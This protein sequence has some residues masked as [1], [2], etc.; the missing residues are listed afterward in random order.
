M[1][2]AFAVLLAPA[3]PGV[4]SA[5]RGLASQTWAELLAPPWIRPDPDHEREGALEGERAED[6]R[7]ARAAVLAM[8]AYIRAA[9][10]TRSADEGTDSATGE[11]DEY[12]GGRDVDMGLIRSLF[13]AGS[14]LSCYTGPR[15]VPWSGSEQGEL[16]DFLSYLLRVLGLHP[17]VTVREDELLASALTSAGARALDCVSH[18][19]LGPAL[20]GDAAHEARTGLPRPQDAALAS[21]AAASGTVPRA[22][23]PTPRYVLEMS[24]A[25]SGQLAPAGGRPQGPPFVGDLFGFW[26]LGDTESPTVAAY[27]RGMPVQGNWS[28]VAPSRHA[29]AATL[30]L[31]D[32]AASLA[33]PRSVVSL[34]IWQWCYT[35]EAVACLRTQPAAAA[36]LFPVPALAKD[37]AARSVPPPTA[38]DMIALRGA[39]DVDD[40]K[41][42]AAPFSPL[43]SLYMCLFTASGQLDVP[44]VEESPATAVWRAGSTALRFE[45]RYERQSLKYEQEGGAAREGGAR[46][47]DASS[48]RARRRS[49]ATAAAAGAR[50]VSSERGRGGVRASAGPA[51]QAG[52]ADAQPGEAGATKRAR[53]AASGDRSRALARQTQDGLAAPVRAR[54]CIPVARSVGVPAYIEARDAA[55]SGPGPGAGAGAGAG[56]GGVAAGVADGDGGRDSPPPLCVLTL[57]G[58]AGALASPWTARDEDALV[59]L[60]AVYSARVAVHSGERHRF[61]LVAPLLWDVREGYPLSGAPLDDALLR[62]ARLSA[63]LYGAGTAEERAA[64][65]RAA[66]ALR[67]TEAGGVVEQA[68]LVSSVVTASALSEMPL[69]MLKLTR[70]SAAPAALLCLNLQNASLRRA[71]APARAPLVLCLPPRSGRTPGGQTAADQIAELAP[72]AVTSAKDAAE[73]LDRDS[74][75]QRKFVDAWS[76]A[77]A[78]GATGRKEVA[79]AQ[80]NGGAHLDM[81]MLVDASTDAGFAA[82]ALLFTSAM[83]PSTRAAREALGEL[84]DNVEHLHRDMIRRGYADEAALVGDALR[85]HPALR[86]DGAA[87]APRE[88]DAGMLAEVFMGAPPHTWSDAVLSAERAMRGLAIGPRQPVGARSVRMTAQVCEHLGPLLV[89]EVQSVFRAGGRPV[90]L[91][92]DADIQS[93]DGG[94]ARRPRPWSDETSMVLSVRVGGRRGGERVEKL[95]LVGAALADA[96]SDESGAAGHY[97]ALVR[98][99]SAAAG[100]ADAE[101][102]SRVRPLQVEPWVLVD[103]GAEAADPATAR[104][105]PPSEAQRLIA[106]RANILVYRN[107]ARRLDR[108]RSRSGEEGA[109]RAPG[110]YA[111]FGAG[112]AAARAARRVRMAAYDMVAKLLGS[113]KEEPLAAQQR[114]DEDASS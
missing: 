74:D 5:L 109:R 77:V 57:G 79:R 56:G 69:R 21:L 43:Y 22:G 9:A 62:I 81:W 92:V 32:S 71:A 107:P 45:S 98:L 82:R 89:V 2:A 35:R 114:V 51:G 29:A 26:R 61:V 42:V 53:V 1:H 18:T 112:A 67:L 84:R 49:R 34:T 37:R 99:A 10:L 20:A 23:D 104:V 59:P 102:A 54:P 111:P 47:R 44:C 38:A 60:H 36:V 93:A 13:D 25:G 41:S 106:R 27:L 85:A 17:L 90:I 40:D 87:G 108:I 4:S 72:V 113:G 110:P 64:A 78:S 28:A 73:A 15:G 46:G 55:R 100:S 68:A 95:E 88:A 33:H 39:F 76:A 31:S 8:A 6:A 105:V 52:G 80:I 50:H 83:L 101:H 7:A 94:D 30:A 63:S 96:T 97:T 11:A 58:A 24:A 86:H 66:E 103:S 70:G 12:R 65:G 19:R 75:L 3:I 48:G 14:P 16:R 91:V